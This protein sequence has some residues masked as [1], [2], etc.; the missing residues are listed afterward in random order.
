MKTEH[1]KINGDLHLDYELVLHGMVT[2][3][4]IVNDG[5]IFVLNG[6]CCSNLSIQNGR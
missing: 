3:N 1:G 4:V 6:M 5:G 2:G